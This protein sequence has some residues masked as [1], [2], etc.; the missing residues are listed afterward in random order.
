ML[1]QQTGISRREF[2]GTA[3]SVC[4]LPMFLKSSVLGREGYISPSERIVS[5]SIGVGNRGGDIIGGF[6]NNPNFQH[7]G[8]CDCYRQR[9]E[10]QKQRV[11][12]WHKNKDTIIFEKYEDVLARE[13]VDAV[14]VATPDH[15]HTKISVE[16][17]KAGKDIYCEKPLTLTPQESRLIV[18]AARKYNRVCSSGSQRVMEDYGYM[19]P[20]IQS[21][22]IGEVKEVYCGLG[23]PGRPCYLP[24]QPLPEGLDWD[25]WLGPAQYA[26]YHSERMSGNYGGGWR[27]YEDYG[28]GFLA[29]WG[30]HKFGGSLYVLGM[31]L[32]EPVKILPPGYDS[33]FLTLVFANGVRFY[34]ATSGNHDITIIG[35]EGEYRHH[36][37]S[38][39]PLK[40][41]DVRRY[42]G[43]VG[44][45][46]EDFA[47]CVKHRLRPFQD[48]A[49]GAN[50]ALF[51][52]LANIGHKLNRPL[53]WDAKKT[54]F[55]NDDLA[56]RW[57]ARVPRSPYAFSI[58]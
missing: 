44:N 58:D 23:A 52:Q 1:K 27:N 57:V 45:I 18:A 39:K 38:L 33:E 34:H 51:C 13:N 11:D 7:I 31:D 42:H 47:Y 21:G 20:I 12:E 50:T 28:N 29:D 49:Y 53:E 5:V 26:P 56:N 16:A 14:V 2:L 9:A 36:R 3:A 32:E 22:A 35:T 40:T 55:V 6:A 46:L 43:G 54:Q 30:A 8:V 15:W 48:F 4:V 19:A 41:V 10:R 24:E 17:C 25:R 37:T